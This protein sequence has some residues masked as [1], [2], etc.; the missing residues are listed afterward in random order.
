[1]IEAATDYSL[2]FYFFF[3]YSMNV[4]KKK[5]K[6]KESIPYLVIPSFLAVL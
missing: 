2:I 3:E 5:K 6:N 4:E 1:M